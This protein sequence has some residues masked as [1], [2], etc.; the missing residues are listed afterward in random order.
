[1]GFKQSLF[2]DWDCP[3]IECLAKRFRCGRISAPDRQFRESIGQ[4]AVEV[5]QDFVEL[6]FRL[7]DRRFA[8]NSGFHPVTG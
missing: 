3:L 6:V 1:M 8:M 4:N 5:G 7:R 2:V